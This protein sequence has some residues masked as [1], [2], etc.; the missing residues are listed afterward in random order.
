M[1]KNIKVIRSIILMVILSTIMSLSIAVVGYS[2][3]RSINNNSSLMYEDAL[4]KIIKTED[5]RETFSGI[6]MNVNRLTIGGFNED[7]VKNI[8]NYNSTINK[9]ISDYEN[10]NLSRIE[11]N[12]LSEF[13][14]EYVS[15]YAQIKKFES[16]EM[17][18]GIDLE[19]FNQ[20]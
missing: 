15:Y 4:I 17:L 13:K 11:K 18:Y 8:D 9:K 1:L 7:D 19:K 20:F 14:K 5:I 6:R 10:L 12:N 2:N 16:G 3:M